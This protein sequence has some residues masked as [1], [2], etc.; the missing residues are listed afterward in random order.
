MCAGA[1]ETFNIVLLD[2]EQVSV[3]TLS[4]AV[5]SLPMGSERK[6]VIVRDYKL[7]QPTGDMK[8]YLPELLA[9]LPEYVCLVFYFDS[10]EFKA[11]KRLNLWKILEKNRPTKI[12]F[13]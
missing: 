1:F 7:L 11:D 4:D 8:E 13:L 12:R 3:Q 10:M 9:N 2:G 5:D 6:L